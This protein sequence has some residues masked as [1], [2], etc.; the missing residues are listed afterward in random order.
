MTLQSDSAAYQCVHKPA[1]MLIHAVC[2]SAC[3]LLQSDIVT[4]SRKQKQFNVCEAFC[5]KK[6][7]DYLA[8]LSCIV[9]A[10]SSSRICA[11]CHGLTEHN[12]IT[13]CKWASLN[14]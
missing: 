12:A 13:G 14:M 2:A 10:V 4:C 3:V 11:L 7:T 8:C 6:F 1:R 5:K 9:N